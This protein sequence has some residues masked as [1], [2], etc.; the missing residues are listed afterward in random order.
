MTAAATIEIDRI[1]HRNRSI[2]F[3]LMGEN[4]KQRKMPRKI[5]D[6]KKFNFKY[7]THSYTNSRGKK[8]HYIYDFGW[9]EFSD[10]EVLII[11]KKVSHK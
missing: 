4:S 6:K 8:Y 7:H 3:E 10:Q 11:R 5:L 1:L 2:L 9:M